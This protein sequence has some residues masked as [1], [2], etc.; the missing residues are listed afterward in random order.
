MTRTNELKRKNIS[1]ELFLIIATRARSYRKVKSSV[2]GGVVYDSSNSLQKDCVCVCFS[3]CMSAKELSPPECI[4][5]M[6]SVILLLSE[7][8]KNRNVCVFACL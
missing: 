5:F 6:A 7:Y 2:Q 1:F 3:V 4:C 8:I